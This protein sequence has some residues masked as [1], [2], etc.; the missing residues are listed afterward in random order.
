MK[1]YVKVKFGNTKKGVE[2]T[3][4]KEYAVYVKAPPIKGKANEEAVKKLAKHFNTKEVRIVS[5]RK[6]SKKIVSVKEDK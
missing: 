4:E 1:I 5:G 3:G 2:K 6:S